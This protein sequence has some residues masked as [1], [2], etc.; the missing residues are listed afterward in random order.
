MKTTLL[1][2][3]ATIC[4]AALLLPSMVQAAPSNPPVNPKALAVLQRMSDT[5]AAAKAFSFKSSPTPAT[6]MCSTTTRAIIPIT[7]SAR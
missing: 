3:L 4:A 7:I 5:L 2:T 1:K 6:V